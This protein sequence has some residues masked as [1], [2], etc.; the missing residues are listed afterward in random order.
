[1]TSDNGKI[2]HLYIASDSAP[3]HKLPL[4]LANRKTGEVLRT[5]VLILVPVVAS[6]LL[7]AAELRLR[8]KICLTTQWQK[9]WSCGRQKISIIRLVCAQSEVLRT[10]NHSNFPSSRLQQHLLRHVAEEGFIQTDLKQDGGRGRQRNCRD[11]VI[12]L[13][14]KRGCAFEPLLREKSRASRPVCSSKS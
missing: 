10:N 2:K 7:M 8:G 5:N 4:I 13:V 11:I 14:Y 6:L 3:G 12:A 1:V 9:T